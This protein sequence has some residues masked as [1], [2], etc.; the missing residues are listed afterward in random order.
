M[1]KPI[2]FKK[3]EV[4]IEVFDNFFVE[5]GDYK[6]NN[7][8]KE[9]SPIW[10]R[11]YNHKG[12]Y[13]VF[14]YIES[15]NSS[16]LKK[17]YEEYYVNG[18][19]EGATTGLSVDENKNKRNLLRSEPLAAHLEMTQKNQDLNL[20]DFYNELYQKFKIPDYIN[21]GQTWGWDIGD[22]FIHF[23][24]Q[25]YVYFLDIMKSILENYN[26]NRTCFIGD[27][28][29]L[30]SAL[31]YENFEVKS[32][33]HIDMAHFLLRQYINSVNCDTD[34]KHVFAEN[35]DENM[36]HD[37]QIMINQD[38]FPE[39]PLDSMKKYV[40]NMDKNNVPFI[41]SYNIENGITFNPHHIDYRKVILDHGYQS[42]WR[43]DSQVRPPYVFELFYKESSSK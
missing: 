15:K 34:I 37:T 33:I 9:S 29:G 17:I 25:D 1:K 39:M 40:Q 31:L 11:I 41:L 4:D 38:S 7:L 13:D 27:G 32:S 42:I 22:N 14:D 24:I 28:T 16:E 36:E 6:R 10:T 8:E 35:F 23:E 2:R 5:C 26:L 18:I 43:F 12:G 3:Q 19:S 20:T 21:I 30:M